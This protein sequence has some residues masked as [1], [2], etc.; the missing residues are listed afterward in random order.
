LH[1]FWV[2]IFCTGQIRSAFESFL[3]RIVSD[4]LLLNLKSFSVQSTNAQ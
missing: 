1:C 3:T 4:A 2:A